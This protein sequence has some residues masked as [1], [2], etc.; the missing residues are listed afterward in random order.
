MDSPNRGLVEWLPG[1]HEPPCMS[2]YQTTHRHYP[3]NKQ[4]PIAFRN[5]VKETEQSLARRFSA[6]DIKFLLEPYNALAEDEDFWNHTLD[7]LAI[8]GA[9]D[10][11]RVYRLQ[12]PVPELVVVANSFHMKP[13]ML[14]L[15]SVDRYQVLG[16]NREEVRLFEGNRNVLDEIEIAP[17]V[18]RTSVE[19]LGEEHTEPHLTVASYGKGAGGPAMRHG[20]GSRKDEL[21]KDTERFFRAVDRAIYE[22]H[23]QPSGLRLMLVALPEYHSLYHGGSHNP[24]LMQGGVDADPNSLTIEELG[25]RTWAV[26]EPHYRRRLQSIVE[27]FQEARP[28]NLAAD[29]PSVIAEAAVAGRVAT[30]LIDADRQVPGRIDAVSGAVEYDDLEDPEV[31]DLLDDLGELVLQM[32]GQVLVVPSEQMPAESGAAAIFRY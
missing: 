30:L 8:L 21:D 22:H 1:Y 23:S 18:P 20:H 15:Q 12:Q 3:E 13:L 16:I 24:F 10:F 4:D 28:K 27:Q 11:F 2:L 14:I 25:Q 17:G 32:G 31:D 7:G 9:Q 19:A 29:A 5:L 6:R 26:M